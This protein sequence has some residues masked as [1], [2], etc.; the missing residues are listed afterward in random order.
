MHP[1]LI[2]GK[3]GV[4]KPLESFVDLPV[5]MFKIISIIMK[6]GMQEHT[7][8]FKEKGGDFKIQARQY[9]CCRISKQQV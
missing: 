4:E 5:V 3:A 7:H 2:S 1:S 9:M 8:K 6:K